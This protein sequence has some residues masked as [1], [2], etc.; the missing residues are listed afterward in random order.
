MDPTPQ[1]SFIPK[2]SLAAQSRGGMFGGLLFLLA[3]GIFILSLAAAGGV[4]TYE[5]WLN[6]QLADKDASLRKD[7]GAFAPGTIQ[8]YL[9]VDSRIVQARA[10]LTRHVSPSVVFAFL[11]TI[12]LEKV[13]FTSFE[14]QLQGDGSGKII[15]GGVG[16]SF[17]T[18]ALQSDAFGATRDLKD[19]VFSGVN[20]GEGGKVSFSVN[21]TVDPALILYSRSLTAAAPVDQ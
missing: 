16:D 7:Q 18:V 1:S 5:K 14:L 12:A 15:L 17:S 8:N 19:V 9:R 13:Q 6:G 2:Q 11:S 3:L 20:V 4:F 10:L 21:A